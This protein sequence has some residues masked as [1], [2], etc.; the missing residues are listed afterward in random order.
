MEPGSAP[1]P[2]RAQR[3]LAHRV[4]AERR[5]TDALITRVDALEIEVP[6]GQVE[7][8]EEL[9][10]LEAKLEAALARIAKLEASDRTPARQRG[11]IGTLRVDRSAPGSE[12]SDD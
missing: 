10:A 1:S 9:D 12:P 3:E 8:H 5:R 2:D 7:L 11:V 6:L 4:E